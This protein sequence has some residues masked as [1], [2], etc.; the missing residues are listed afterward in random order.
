MCSTNT[1]N[2]NIVEMMKKYAIS[3]E[4]DNG[5]GAVELYKRGIEY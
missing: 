3:V 1:N 2:W 4:A 5:L